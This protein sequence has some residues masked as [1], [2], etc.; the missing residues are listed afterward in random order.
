MAGWW[1][2]FDVLRIHADTAR[3]QEADRHVITEFEYA[4][5]KM[6]A[7]IIT[8]GTMYFFGVWGIVVLTLPVVLWDAYD[9][10]TKGRCYP[11]IRDMVI[12]SSKPPR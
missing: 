9:Y 7:V 1:W 10:V 5:L 6:L 12:R 2:K 11:A 3:R 8:V 4:F